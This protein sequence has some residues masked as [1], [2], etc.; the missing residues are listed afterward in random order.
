MC[1]QVWIVFMLECPYHTQHF[2]YND[3]FNWTATYRRDSDI[4]T[5]YEK[6][7]YYDDRMKQMKLPVKNFAANKTKQVYLYLNTALLL[8]FCNSA[9]A[10]VLV[11]TFFQASVNYFSIFIN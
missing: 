1:A 11:Q 4:V 2:K 9:F 5:P 6:W 8:Y 10:L 7:V 3:L